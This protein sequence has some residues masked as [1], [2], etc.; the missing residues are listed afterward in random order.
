MRRELSLWGR[1]GVILACTAAS[2]ALH[3]GC[4]RCE[5]PDG[6][7]RTESARSQP[8]VASSTSPQA[9]PEVAGP[10]QS[11]SAREDDIDYSRI[12]L[13]D[14]PTPPDLR[15]STAEPKQ[16]QRIFDGYGLPWHP[17]AVHLCGKRLLH[18]GSEQSVWDAFWSK[19]TPQK[20]VADYQRRLSKR[21]FGAEAPGGVWKLPEGSP[22][23]RRTLRILKVDSPGEHRSCD[24]TPAPE[25]RSVIILTRRH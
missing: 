14:P 1:A 9:G 15:S 22:T 18:P 10:A 3:S 12:D 4:S 23:P 6:A 7:G 20:L 16:D 13:P 11:A 19:S 8:E 2:T 5:R 17:T 21:G 24:E 25:A